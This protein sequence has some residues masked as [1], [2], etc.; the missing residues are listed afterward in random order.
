MKICLGYLVQS[1]FV[2]PDDLAKGWYSRYDLSARLE[3]SGFAAGCT[4]DDNDNITVGFNINRPL[5]ELLC[6]SK[7]QASFKTI[8]C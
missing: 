1:G 5:D 3:A 2:N 6:K 7:G 8:D 4:F